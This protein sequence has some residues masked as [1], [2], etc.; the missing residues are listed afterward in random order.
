MRAESGGPGVECRPGSQA[1]DGHVQLRASSTPG[2][3][4]ARPHGGAHGRLAGRPAPIDPHLEVAGVMEGARRQAALLIKPKVEAGCSTCRMI[5]K[6]PAVLPGR[7]V[8]R[9]FGID[10]DGI[11]EFI[12]RARRAEAAGAGGA[13]PRRTRPHRRHRPRAHAAGAPPA[14]EDA[15]RSITAGMV[16]VRDPDTGTYNA[17]Y[18]RLQLTGPGRTGVKLDY[19]RHLRLA[20][21]APG[22][23]ARRSDRG[24]HR[25]DPPCV[26]RRRPWARGCPSTP[27]SWRSPA[28]CAVAAG[29]HEGRFAGSADSGG[30]RDRA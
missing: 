13:R 9:S 28:G 7:Y 12:G 8:K 29:G 20:W 25:S 5:E 26:I 22:A 21:S 10:F 24:V 23:R 30:D 1:R 16:I 4:G 15:G 19:G 27:T 2:S 3:V 18:H 14:G 11:R 17:S 6:Q